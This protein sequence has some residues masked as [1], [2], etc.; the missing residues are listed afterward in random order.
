[1]DKASASDAGGL[2][3][4]VPPGSFLGDIFKF[5]EQEIHGC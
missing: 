3:V 2:W 5:T 1:M 4:E